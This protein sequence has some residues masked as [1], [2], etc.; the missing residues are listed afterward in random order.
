MTR[1]LL[2][3]ILL[4]TPLI[5]NPTS[6][7]A[8][9]AEVEKFTPEVNSTYNG[10]VIKIV[11]GDTVDIVFMLGFGVQMKHRVR[12]LGVYAAEKA[13]DDGKKHADNLATLLPLGKSVVVQAKKT[14]K[15]G[16]SLADIWID[17]KHVNF[18]QQKFIGTPQGKGLAPTPP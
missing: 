6:E 3:L 7:E 18:L 2:I 8:E 9:K 11:D 17:G 10:I 14:D 5:A 12:M 4:A 13:E 1:I 16:R 15:Y